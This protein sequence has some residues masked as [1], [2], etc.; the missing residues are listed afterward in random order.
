M[1]KA[2]VTILLACISLLFCACNKFSIGDIT[3]V[4]APAGI[5]VPYQSATVLQREETGYRGASPRPL[6]KEGE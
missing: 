6:P 3:Q 2:P 4:E 5:E 1:K